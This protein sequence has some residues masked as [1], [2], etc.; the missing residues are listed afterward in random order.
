MIPRMSDNERA[1]FMSFVSKSER[2]L[3][4][5]TWREYVCSLVDAEDV[6]TVG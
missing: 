5:G 1:L 3:E 2:Y 6:D 4:F